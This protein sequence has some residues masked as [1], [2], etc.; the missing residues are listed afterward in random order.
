MIK[1]VVLALLAICLI[2]GVAIGY[3]SY[4]LIYGSALELDSESIS[5]YIKS[6]WDEQDVLESLTNLA[7]L[8]NP[9]F[10]ERLIEQKKLQR[11][12]GGARKVY[13]DG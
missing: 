12:F 11:K 3:Y 2:A 4:K 13:L 5:F 8:R 6:D 9:V 7:G 10:A 1:K